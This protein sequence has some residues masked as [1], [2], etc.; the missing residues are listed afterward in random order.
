[1]NVLI[2]TGKLEFVKKLGDVSLFLRVDIEAKK[3]EL[4]ALREKDQPYFKKN[5]LFVLE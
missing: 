2:K 1:M 3:N 5:N 4:E